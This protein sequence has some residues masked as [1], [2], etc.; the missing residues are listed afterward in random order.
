MLRVLEGELKPE[1]FTSVVGAALGA[2][3]LA[4]DGSAE[5]A[6]LLAQALLEELRKKGLDVDPP[7]PRPRLPTRAVELGK[8]LYEEERLMLP[9]RAELAEKACFIAM[10]RIVE[11]SQSRLEPALGAALACA[12]LL[13]AFAPKPPKPPKRSRGG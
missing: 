9:H 12:G 2:Q 7:K 13:G 11:G 4:T 8:R 6:E 5:R 10:V 3:L 1:M